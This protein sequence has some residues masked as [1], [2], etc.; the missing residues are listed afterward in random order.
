MEKSDNQTPWKVIYTASRQEKKVAVLLERFGIAYYLPVVKKLRLW[1]DRKKWVEMPLFNGYV[2]VKPEPN[3]RDKVLEIP[4]VVKYLK[5]N[6][7]DAEVSDNE[8]KLIQ[9][10]IETGY[11]VESA[12][13][14]NLKKGDI[15][16]IQQGPL[17]GIEAEVLKDADGSEYILLAFETISQVVRVSLPVAILKTTIKV[18]HV[19]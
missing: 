7:A 1:S 10:L 14:E 8:L 11:N 13:R 18:N 17:K 9:Q 19:R 16:T 15:V 4:G 6:G 2:F 5:H 3:M 12:D